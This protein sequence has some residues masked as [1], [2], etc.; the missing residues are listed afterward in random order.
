MD[1]FIKESMSGSSVF[2]ETANNQVNISAKLRI[3][4][5]A[6][7]EEGNKSEDYTKCDKAILAAFKEI[8]KVLQDNIMQRMANAMQ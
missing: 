1:E 3:K 4:A 8:S 5:E 7:F 6:A 2:G